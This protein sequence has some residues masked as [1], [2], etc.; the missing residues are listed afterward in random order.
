MCKKAVTLL[1][2]F[3]TLR[4]KILIDNFDQKNSTNF[5]F[6]QGFWMNCEDL[7]TIKGF[8]GI[9]IAFIQIKIKI[10]LFHLTQ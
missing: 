8:N 4:W 5:C 9:A 6:F 7:T 3:I 10:F 2:E 1:Y